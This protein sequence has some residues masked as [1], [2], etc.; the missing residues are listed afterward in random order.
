MQLKGRAAVRGETW[1]R[2]SEDVT[3]LGGERGE[4]WGVAIVWRQAEGRTLCCEAD[5]ANEELS[6]VGERGAGVGEASQRVVRPCSRGCGGER[7]NGGRAAERWDPQRLAAE[8]RGLA[9]AHE[10]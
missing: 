6:A 7:G 1:R 3:I 2:A 9:E 4:V 8:R 5:T 10:L